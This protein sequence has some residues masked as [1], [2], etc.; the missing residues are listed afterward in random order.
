MIH[1]EQIEIIQSP[2]GAPLDPVWGTLVHT[3][4]KAAI[5]IRNRLRV[6]LH[7]ALEVADW[8]YLHPHRDVQGLTK[9]LYRVSKDSSKRK[10]R[11]DQAPYCNRS[12]PSRNRNSAG[13]IR[14]LL[15]TLT[16][17]TLPSR[18]PF[19]NSRKP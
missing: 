3:A 18:L 6:R 9:T 14:R 10:N 4:S 19:Q 5:M 12:R 17:L 16:R 11:S 15:Q 1:E 8:I 13:S 7:E 2:V